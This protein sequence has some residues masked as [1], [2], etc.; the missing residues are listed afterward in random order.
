MLCLLSSLF[1]PI[2][3]FRRDLLLDDEKAVEHSGGQRQDGKE[4]HRGE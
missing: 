4:I 3:R 2:F 1:I